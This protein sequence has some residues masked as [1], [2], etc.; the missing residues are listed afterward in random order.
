MTQYFMIVNG[1]V[2]QKSV[3]ICWCQSSQRWDF[4]MHLTRDTPR[5]RGLGEMNKIYIFLSKPHHKLNNKFFYRQ[6][7]NEQFSELFIHE[8]DAKWSFLFYSFRNDSI[9]NVCIGK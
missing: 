1:K 3:V 7:Q 8:T 9:I 2:T 5:E 4:V 6:T